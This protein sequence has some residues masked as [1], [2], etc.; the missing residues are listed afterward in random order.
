MGPDYLPDRQP[1]QPTLLLVLRRT[2][3]QVDFQALSPLTYRLL[4]RLETFPTLTG[5]A[6]LEALAEEASAPDVAAFVLE[7]AT[8]LSQL[9][10]DCVLIGTQ[11]D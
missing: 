2:D 3:G 9:R 4:E 6:Q 11:P 1:A 10:D 5:R 7:G 8:M